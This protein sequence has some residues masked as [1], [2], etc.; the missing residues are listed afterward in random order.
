MFFSVL[1][2]EINL[3]RA[4]DFSCHVN[5]AQKTGSI[6]YF[7][8]TI[9]PIFSSQTLRINIKLKRSE[10]IEKRNEMSS[11]QRKKAYAIFSS[12]QILSLS[13]GPIL[14]FRFKLFRWHILVSLKFISYTK[15]LRTFFFLNCN[16]SSFWQYFHKRDLWTNNT[17]R[18]KKFKNVSRCIASLTINSCGIGI[19]DKM[20]VK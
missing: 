10:L 18:K 20:E 6:I 12:W 19:T 16:L 9:D 13:Q 2:W 1:C 15:S 17:E 7:I 14:E 8:F 3:Q 4:T 11:Q 5:H